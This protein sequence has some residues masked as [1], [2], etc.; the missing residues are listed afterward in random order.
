MEENKVEGQE[1]PTVAPEAAPVEGE[2]VEPKV[3]E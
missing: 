1:E 2:N 3:E